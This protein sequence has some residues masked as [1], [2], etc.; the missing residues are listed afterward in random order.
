[1]LPIRKISSSRV[2]LTSYYGRIFV[3]RSEK[4]V[5]NLEKWINTRI[6][7]MGADPSNNLVTD[8]V[9]G[10]SFINDE[11]M[12]RTY[13]ILSK[14]FRSFKLNIEQG[15][16]QITLFPKVDTAEYELEK[17]AKEIDPSYTLLGY[18]SATGNSIVLDPKDNAFIYNSATAQLQPFGFLQSLGLDPIK[19]PVEFSTC[20]I[21]GAE[22]PVGAVLGYYVGLA[23][24]CSMLKV[25]PRRVPAGK[26]ANL[27]EDEWAMVFE[28]Q[29]LV[30]SRKDKLATLVLSG[31][32]DFHRTLSQY[33]LAEFNHRDVYLMLMEEKKIGA[34]HLREMDLLSQLFVDPITRELLADMKEP[35]TFRELL[36]RGSEL[37][38]TDWHPQEQ[39][40]SYMRIKGYE[41]M[42]GILY[43]E[44]VKA[45][46][47]H[48][49]MPG[50]A[51]YGVELNPHEVWIAIQQDSAKD[52]VS[53]INPI[54]D[55]KQQEALTYSGVGGRSSRTMVA[56]TRVFHKTDMGVT[57]ESTVDSSDVA[58]NAYMSANPKIKNVRGL[59]ERFDIEKDGISSLMST[60]AMVSPGAMRDD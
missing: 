36:V 8:M 33:P 5:N 32:R 7:A 22:V 23:G 44:L 54:Q 49:S 30:F 9:A 21:A 48:N 29:T 25:S 57:S 53:D 2:A 47:K 50:K 6:Y 4:R 16:F 18:D 46:R 41:R 13:S 45:V 26:R 10:L 37:L 35:L 24:L 43:G 28:D 14:G 56:R 31:F 60:S 19:A 42:T 3:D 52:Q 59:T 1:M 27:Q 12:P 51:R 20:N 40:A 34:R 55:L 58:V 38:L 39:D 11:H 17:K 15:S